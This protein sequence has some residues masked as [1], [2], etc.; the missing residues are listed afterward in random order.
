MKMPS[1]GQVG[2]SK[3]LKSLTPNLKFELLVSMVP[4]APFGSNKAMYIDNDAL[5]KIDVDFIEFDCF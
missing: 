3:I 5:T 4:E 1:R 2:G